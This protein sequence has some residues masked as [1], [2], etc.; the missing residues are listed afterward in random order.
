MHYCFPVEVN[1][2][3]PSFP[4]QSTFI[5]TFI[6]RYTKKAKSQGFGDNLIFGFSTPKN[7]LLYTYV[8]GFHFHI[9]DFQRPP[10]EV[11]N[12][13]DW[14]K[15]HAVLFYFVIILNTD[16]KNSIRYVQSMPQRCYMPNFSLVAQYLVWF[17]SRCKFDAAKLS[18]PPPFR[19]QPQQT[20]KEIDRLNIGKNNQFGM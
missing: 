4:P 5:I 7:H 15:R 2:Y 13:K 14:L 20:Y 16:L 18:F 6:H 10:M 3:I 1:Q 8:Q 11:N 9:F 19:M 17:G 12:I